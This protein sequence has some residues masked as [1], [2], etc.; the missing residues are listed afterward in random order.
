MD[1]LTVAMIA[2]VPMGALGVILFSRV[3]TRHRDMY[4]SMG[5]PSLIDWYQFAVVTLLRG[6]RYRALARLERAMVIAYM[7][8][9]AIFICACALLLRSL[10]A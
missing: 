5:R 7:V 2:G 9:L 3:S 6:D 1:W 4:E 8:A 10:L